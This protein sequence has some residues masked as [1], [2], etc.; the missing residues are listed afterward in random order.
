[1][2]FRTRYRPA[3]R[4][5]G[6]T[7]LLAV[8]GSIGPFF[9]ARLVVQPHE[10][11]LT[12]PKLATRGTNNTNTG[13]TH[14][15]EI[16][17]ASPISREALLT[18]GEDLFIRKS[19]SGTFS[20]TNHPRAR[21]LCD[22]LDNL[23]GLKQLRDAYHKDSPERRKLFTDCMDALERS[24]QLFRE[25]FPNFD[26]RTCAELDRELL[27]AMWDVRQNKK[28]IPKTALLGIISMV[29]SYPHGCVQLKVWVTSDSSKAVVES[30]LNVYLRD[31]VFSVER[32]NFGNLCH[33]IVHLHPDLND[34][35]SLARPTLQK[36]SNGPPMGENLPAFSDI[37]RVFVLSAYGGVYLDCDMVLLRPL[38]PLLSRDFYYRWSTHVYANTAAMHLKLGSP[39]AHILIK[40][41]LEDTSFPGWD[42]WLSDKVF[43]SNI[44][45]SMV[46][47][48]ATI[49]LL[50]S[51]YFDPLWVGNEG[52][53]EAMDAANSRYGISTFGKPFFHNVNN[54]T[55]V[56]EDARSNF[57]PGVFAFHFHNS[58][59]EK[60]VPG[61]T[62]DLLMQ[63]FT[64]HQV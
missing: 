15:Y 19:L 38:T 46:K 22:K 31:D 57:F 4:L 50:P 55:S 23:E 61:S 10:P 49:E 62:A 25:T 27:H 7:L 8:I 16:P 30:N 11:S 17:P 3:V 52:Y 24:Q 28:S 20:S 36:W 59:K 45:H 43:P 33:R 47:R 1:M 53:W 2:P 56:R 5:F 34:T 40:W 39:N 32:L 13:N 44:Y 6:F 9:V 37:V 21:T 12:T 42:V 29:L 14:S 58:W 60:F 41:V 48:N 35:V 54:V 18:L 63:Q 64:Q 26:N 51:S